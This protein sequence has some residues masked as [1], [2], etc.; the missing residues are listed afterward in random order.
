MRLINVVLLAAA[1]A[2]S[3]QTSA[4]MNEYASALDPR[5]PPVSAIISADHVPELSV[6]ANDT[7]EV[8]VPGLVTDGWIVPSEET[9][10]FKL[11]RIQ[12]VNKSYGEQQ[13]K[14]FFEGR[15][16]PTD[17]TVSLKSKNGVYQFK[18]K[19]RPTPLC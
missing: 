13:V 19:P 7:I 15:R 12:Q 18:I 16:N 1:L 4:C 8:T 2:T 9:F 17:M 6:D 10:S 3:F 14:L 5:V 11:I